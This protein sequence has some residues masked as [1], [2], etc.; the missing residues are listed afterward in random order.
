MLTVVTGPAPALFASTAKQ[1]ADASTVNRTV[2]LNARRTLCALQATSEDVF[3]FA[4]KCIGSRTVT[5]NLLVWVE[6]ICRG[7]SIITPR[8]ERQIGMIV[9]QLHLLRIGRAR[10]LSHKT[11]LRVMKFPLSCTLF[12]I[13][14]RLLKPTKNGPSFGRKAGAQAA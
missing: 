1:G 7:A 2:S 14:S 12:L 9:A 8:A 4:T 6:A 3:A 10:C 13:E 11:H 5:T